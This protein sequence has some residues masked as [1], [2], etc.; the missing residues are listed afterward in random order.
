MLVTIIGLSMEY[1]I[2]VKNTPKVRLLKILLVLW[3]G[4]G[5]AFNILFPS[6]RLNSYL[7]KK[8]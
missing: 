8:R 6:V 7:N 3:F 2:G 5:N 1:N 4:I